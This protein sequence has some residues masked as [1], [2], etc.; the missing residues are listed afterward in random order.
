MITII[1][2]N[3]CNRD[4]MHCFLHKEYNK[5]TNLYEYPI[6]F[7][8][9]D[10]NNI[11]KYISIISSNKFREL[12][13]K[14]HIN[15]ISLFSLGDIMMEDKET[16]SNIFF[17]V[18]KLKALYPFIKIK[19]QTN[20]IYHITEEMES[21]LNKVDDI[22]T[23]FD[24]HTRFKSVRDI[25]LWYTNI[26]HW[27]KIKPI[28]LEIVATNKM[29]DVK[30]KLIR[31]LDKLIKN[32]IIDSFYIYPLTSIGNAKYNNLIPN[33]TDDLIDLIKD[34]MEL[35]VKANT[36]IDA[37]VNKDYFKIYDIF[38]YPIPVLSLNSDNLIEFLYY[39]D[40]KFVI[41]NSPIYYNINGKCLVCQ[42]YN[43]CGGFYRTDSIDETYCPFNITEENNDFM[44][45]DIAL[46]K[47]KERM[48]TNE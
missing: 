3:K 17:L 10:K 48:M 2:G 7:D 40:D 45:Y 29:I 30:R 25:I 1:V 16:L 44:L 38:A 24:I 46:E 4:C 22:R 33:N 18:S 27:S 15:S 13:I 19:L 39:K 41:G 36:I 43:K 32:K 14:K 11:N 23:S 35:D 8:P 12:L 9:L 21:L 47:Y 26:K 34:T 37:L 20:F 6:N 5:K 31:V 42:F 28:K